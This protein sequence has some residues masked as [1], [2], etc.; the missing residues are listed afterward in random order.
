MVRQGPRDYFVQQRIFTFW[1][2]GYS[3][4][5]PGGDPAAEMDFAHEVLADTP[6]NIPVMGWWSY[7]DNKGIPE[8]DAVR[9]CSSYAKFLSGSEFCTNLSVL[10]GIKV[11][12]E[13]FRQT[14]HHTQPTPG[15]SPS[16]L[17]ATMTV[18]DS[19][20]SQWYWQD[21]QHG[22][23]ED[24]AAA[25]SRSTGRSIRPWLTSCRQCSN[26]FTSTRRPTICFSTLSPASAI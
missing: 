16:K 6:P 8:Y 20:D 26:G 5:E 22:L 21:Y 7:S 19:G 17:Y 15:F 1:V 9:L 13:V 11:P 24:P 23:W 14:A 2:S 12:A 3:D 10:S 4:N 18:I 25:M